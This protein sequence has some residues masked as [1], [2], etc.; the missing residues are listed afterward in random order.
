MDYK[1]EG[2]VAKGKIEATAARIGCASASKLCA[3]TRAHSPSMNARAGHSRHHMTAEWGS[4][5]FFSRVGWWW[6][7]PEHVSRCVPLQGHGVHRHLGEGAC[8]STRAAIPMQ[9][10]IESK[11][12]P[13]CLR[14]VLLHRSCPRVAQL[15]S[16]AIVA[17]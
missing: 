4:D 9:S 7:S 17:C 6:L 11:P 12:P 13:G 1:S 3:N 2:S 10:S 8:G 15:P 14:R 16:A 5:S